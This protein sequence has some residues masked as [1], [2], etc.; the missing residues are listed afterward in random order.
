MKLVRRH[1][2]E[3]LQGSSKVTFFKKWQNVFT[4]SNKVFRINKDIIRKYFIAFAGF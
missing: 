1:D 2:L 4:C 3:L